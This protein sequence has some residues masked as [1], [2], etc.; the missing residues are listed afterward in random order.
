MRINSVQIESY[1]RLNNCMVTLTSTDD[2]FIVENLY[3]KIG[4][5]LIAGP[6]GS[7]KTSLLSFIAQVFHNIQRF[8]KR[9]LGNFCIS[10]TD[11]LGRSCSIYREKDAIDMSLRVVGGFDLP[12]LNYPSGVYENENIDFICYDKACEFLPPV[13]IV[14]AFSLHGE[15]PFERPSNFIGDRRLAVYDI[16]NLYGRNHFS[17]PSFSRAICILMNA[18]KKKS[19]GVKA[20]EKLIGAK[21]TGE[22][23]T[24]ERILRYQ[25]DDEEEWIDYSKGIEDSELAENIY[26]NDIRLR[27]KTGHYLRLSNMSSGQKMLFVRLLT[28]LS[29][30]EDGALILIEEPEIHLDPAWSRQLVSLLL[31]FFRE[32]NAHIIIATHSFSLLNA[33]P[34]NCILIAKDGDFSK[35]QSPTLLANEST[36]SSLLYNINANEVEEK[37]RD[38][39]QHA[40]IDQLD[41]LFDQLGESSVRFDIFS[42]IRKIQSEQ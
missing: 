12:I 24:H 6:N 20:L 1:R 28:I 32:Y 35:P 16:S 33:V 2:S 27:T 18:V 36:L 8:P 14:S 11:R 26:V 37:I 19:S 34:T 38:F 23:L 29:K 39:S 13:I 21:F 10:Y 7:G 31:L 3:G 22:V 9:I 5:T 4:I 30:I 17:F 40:T 15:Y 25:N 42:K 41:R